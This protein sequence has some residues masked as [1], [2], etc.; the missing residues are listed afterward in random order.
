MTRTR[1]HRLT[2]ALLVVCAVAWALSVVLP[3]AAIAPHVWRGGSGM[4]EAIADTPNSSLVFRAGGWMDHLASLSAL[5]LAPLLYALLRGIHRPL[6]GLSAAALLLAALVFPLSPWDDLA[7]DTEWPNRG[8]TVENSRL[9]W[10]TYRLPTPTG[11]S[12]VI[13]EFRYTYSQTIGYA[14]LGSS[15]IALGLALRRIH[16]AGGATATGLPVPGWVGWLAAAAGATWLIAVAG[17]ARGGFFAQFWSIS[18]ILTLGALLTF[19]GLLLWN[20]RGDL[21]RATWREQAA[22]ARSGE[23][24]PRG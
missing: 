11:G 7:S 6:A 8:A 15:L 10:T 18:G 3:M 21:P 2:G 13:R 12:V 23:A 5:A 1:L 19:G 4:Y 16:W 14:A 17:A 9:T 24:S 22:S 20:P